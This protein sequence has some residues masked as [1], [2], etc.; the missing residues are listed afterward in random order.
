MLEDGILI[1]GVIVIL[2]TVAIMGFLTTLVLTLIFMPLIMRSNNIL[3]N[4]I[5]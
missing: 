2:S 5:H 1:L 3:Q 4:T